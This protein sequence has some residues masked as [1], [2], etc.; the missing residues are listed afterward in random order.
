MITSQRGG[1]S[2]KKKKKKTLN[3]QIDIVYFKNF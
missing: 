3:Q 1:Y 2:R